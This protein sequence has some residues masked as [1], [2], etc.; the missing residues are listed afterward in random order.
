MKAAVGHMRESFPKMSE[1]RAC[2]LM[3]MAVSTF[4]YHSNRN[5]EALRR[6][7][8]EMARQRPRFG[9]RRLHVLLK[10]DEPVNHKKV[11]RVYREAGLAVKRR[12]RKRLHRAGKS[13]AEVMGPNQEWALDFVS[14]RIAMGRTIRL[15]NVADAFTR[16]CVALEVD[17][18]FASLRVT[19]VLDE[20]I[21]KRGAPSSLRCDNGPEFTSRHFFAWA[22]E[23]NIDLV[24]IEPGRPMQNGRLES[25]NGKIRDE[26]LNTNWFRNLFDARTQARI[27]KRDYN[28]ARPHSSLAYRTP[29]GFAAQWNSV[30]S[31]FNT[32]ISDEQDRYRGNASG[33]LRAALTA[34][35]L[36]AECSA[37]KGEVTN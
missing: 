33:A 12:I 24:H 18:S 6:E 16:E 15:L 14:D 1:R 4:R 28:E 19:R 5:D 37:E 11:F 3:R 25:L 31:P 27:W 9:Y 29:A 32:A 30:T 17:T 34:A 7:L 36:I 2:G 13:L 22:K 8:I 35:P 21:S 20:A 10:F 26:F 23:R